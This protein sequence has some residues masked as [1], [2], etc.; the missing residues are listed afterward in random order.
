MTRRAWIVIIAIVIAAALL[1]AVGIVAVATHHHDRLTAGPRAMLNGQSGQQGTMGPFGQGNGSGFGQRGPGGSRLE[2]DGWRPLRGLPWLAVG[3]LVGFGAATLAWQPWKQPA[4]A[5]AAG[6][7]IS[8]AGTSDAAQQWA[9]W[10]R[11][12]HAAEQTTEQMT[13]EGAETT[14][15]EPAGAAPPAADTEA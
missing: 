13:A 12:V 1:G 9:Q 3:L 2:R 6:A 11:D 4:P 10:H 15:A 8:D 5:T 14:A 7:A